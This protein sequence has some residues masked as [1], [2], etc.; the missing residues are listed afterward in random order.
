ML[1]AFTM[2]ILL[3]SSVLAGSVAGEPGPMAAPTEATMKSALIKAADWIMTVTGSDGQ[4]SPPFGA[5]A[6]EKTSAGRMSLNGLC[7]LRAYQV[8]N[9]SAYLDRAEACAALATQNI[10]ASKSYVHFRTGVPPLEAVGGFVNIQPG[11]IDDVYD[12]TYTGDVRY[13]IWEALRGML[14]LTQMY[15]ETE[16]LDHLLTASVLDTFINDQGYIGDDPQNGLVDYVILRNDGNWTKGPITSTVEHAVLMTAIWWAREDLANMWSDRFSLMTY[17]K[18]QKKPDGSFDDR[19]TLPG[20]TSSSETQHA[21]MIPAIWELGLGNEAKAL[22]AW[23]LDQQEADGHFECPHDM[24]DYGDT[25]WTVMGLLPYGAISAAADG[26]NWLLGKQLADGSWPF[27]SA[28]PPWAS[29][30]YSTEWATLA[31]YEG[32]RNYNLHINNSMVS[33]EAIWEGTPSRVVGFTV[34]ATV[35][36]QGLIGVKGAR[37]CVYD[38]V[39]SQA[40]L[41]DEVTIDV[42]P[43]GSAPASLEF[44]PPERGPH[45]IVVVVKYDPGGEFRTRDNNALA[46]VNINRDPTGVIMSPNEGQLFPFEARI[47][48]TVSDIKDLDGDAVSYTWTD[49]VTGFLSNEA[50]FAHKLPPGDHNVFLSLDD[51]NGPGTK[52]N[53]SFSVRFNL[54]PTIRISSPADGSDFFDYQKIPFDASASSDA[55]GQELSF[56]WTSDQV[57]ELGSGGTFSRRLTPGTHVITVWVDDGWANISKSVTVDITET[58]PPEIVISSPVDGGEYVSTSR[59]GFDASGTTDPD[60]DF[61]GYFWRSNLQGLLSERTAFLAMLQIGT[62][63]ITLAVNDGN[64]NVTETITITVLNNRPPVVAISKPGMNDEFDSDDVVELNGSLSYDPEDFVTFLWVSTIGGILGDEPVMN[65]VLPRG[66]HRITLWVDDGFGH[67]VSTS[68]NITVL[69]LGPTAGISAPQDGESF[70]AGTNVKFMAGT[71]TDP[72]NDNLNYAWSLRVKDGMWVPFGT[73][74][75][76]DRIFDKEGEFEI[77]LVVRDADYDDETTIKITITPKKE[78]EDGPG[79]GAALVALAILAAVIVT[80]VRRARD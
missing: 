74:E 6:W 5:P 3:S 7:L 44:R 12:D 8:T 63:V 67:N 27:L 71:S 54:P 34:N 40:T 58:F 23:V 14:F 72:E 62:H 33:T 36:N 42:P 57:G 45:T 66:E 30:L 60:S 11:K 79:F 59:I 75:M 35:T 56:H 24:D 64:Y 10:Q 20:Q 76:P 65:L 41:M 77:K 22:V 16:K 25:S 80:R 32:L 4:L 51:G 39:V 2:A 18:Q 1:L 47:T 70:P 43:L 46:Q 31:L 21:L 28:N 68:I 61:L 48:F 73:E 53:V 78:D 69:N 38:G 29:K 17:I 26:L 9:N 19:T 37:V 13:N 15:A 55:E 50:T 49:N 52:M